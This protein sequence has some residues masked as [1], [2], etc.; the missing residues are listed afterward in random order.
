MT[1]SDL[2]FNSH[3]GYCVDSTHVPGNVLSVLTEEGPHF[4]F[5][6]L[7]DTHSIGEKTKV[8]GVEVL[9]QGHGAS[10]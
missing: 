9:T 1:L 5:T 4:I 6:I 7:R 2:C 3:P 8:E 10:N